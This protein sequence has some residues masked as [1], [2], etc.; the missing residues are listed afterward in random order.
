MTQVYANGLSDEAYRQMGEK[1][2]SLLASFDSLGSGWS[3]KE[4]LIV[5]VKSARFRQIHGWSDI[6]LP[7]KKANC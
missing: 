2:M 1:M 3:S 4:L 7:S 5:Y 6:A